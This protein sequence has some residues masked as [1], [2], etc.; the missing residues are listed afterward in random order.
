MGLLK[1]AKSKKQT[2]IGFCETKNADFYSKCKLKIG[3][4][5]VKKFVYR[6]KK[7]RI[8]KDKDDEDVMYLKWKG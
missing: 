2:M 6:D 5:L 4:G 3:R 7:G 1:Y 8:I